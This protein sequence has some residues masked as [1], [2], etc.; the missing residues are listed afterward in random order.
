MIRQRPGAVNHER[1]R[2]GSSVRLTAGIQVVL[3][4]SGPS[5]WLEAEANLQLHL[6]G[7]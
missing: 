4:A 5:D 1:R 2:R 3:N 6:R 7:V